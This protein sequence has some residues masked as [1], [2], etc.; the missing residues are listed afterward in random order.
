MI[1]SEE[2]LADIEDLYLLI[3][4]SS[5]HYKAEIMGI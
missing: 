4:F 2:I 1:N 3:E 5:I